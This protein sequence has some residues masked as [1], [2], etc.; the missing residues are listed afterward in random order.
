MIVE[1]SAFALMR[2]C[3]GSSTLSTAL[4]KCGLCGKVA[5]WKVLLSRGEKKQAKSNRAVHYL[6]STSF[7]VKHG[8]RSMAVIFL[9]M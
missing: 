6:P 5:R 3:F 4:H 9:N 2:D 7:T 8:G 1:Q